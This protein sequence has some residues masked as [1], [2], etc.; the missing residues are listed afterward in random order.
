MKE[1]IFILTTRCNQRCIFCCEPPGDPDMK[2]ENAI[3]W[4]KETA[5]TGIPW[6]DFSGGEP[7]LHKEIVKIVKSSKEFGL[8]NSLST[9]GILLH[10]YY[11]ELT[12][13]IDQWNLS[14]HGSPEIHNRLVN[15]KN[16]YQRI[17][18]SCEQIAENNGL[19]QITYVV[20]K[21]NI[22][23]VKETVI[24]LIN[25]GVKKI[26]FNYIF[27]RGTGKGYL[28]K[29]EYTLEKAIEEISIQFKDIDY[30]DIIIY[31]NIN[32]E[33]QCALV[34]YSG[35]VWAVPMSNGLGYEEAFHIENISY[36]ATHYQYMENHETFT[37]NRLKENSSDEFQSFLL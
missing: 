1:L 25:I 6:V 31:H 30:K 23:E 15:N 20:T 10:K 13:Y 17:L 11:Q 8:K 26:C 24:K 34:R 29:N 4:L 2:S 7:L 9:N 12:G 35:L 18:T 3:R 5:N 32:L 22:S 14:L 16:S 28:E 27:P 19:I 36:F 21:Q 33:G 37:Y